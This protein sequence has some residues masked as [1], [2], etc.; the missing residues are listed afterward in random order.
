MNALYSNT[1]LIV[2]TRE[3]RDIAVEVK[4]L[5][6]RL[7]PKYMALMEDDSALAEFLTGKEEGFADV[8][9]DDAIYAILQAGAELNDPRVA[10]WAEKQLDKAQ[11]LAPLAEKAAQLSQSLPQML[12][13]RMG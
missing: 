10:R 8:L 3:G 9:T 5:P 6:L 13:S 7:L 12:R 1:P 4:A 2:Q 11:R